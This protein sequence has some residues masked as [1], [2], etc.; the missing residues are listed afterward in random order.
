MEFN[1]DP[2]VSMDGNF[3]KKKYENLFDEE[4]LF[5]WS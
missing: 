2:F 5:F 1:N 4:E 3:K